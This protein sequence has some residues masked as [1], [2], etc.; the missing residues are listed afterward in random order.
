MLV[1][2]GF[3]EWKNLTRK[4]IILLIFIAPCN[5]DKILKGEKKALNN[6]DIS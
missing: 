1:Q 3:L 4:N 5:D 6:A 2:Q